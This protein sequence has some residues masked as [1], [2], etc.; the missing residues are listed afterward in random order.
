VNNPSEAVAPRPPRR[1]ARSKP[2]PSTAAS[3]TAAPAKTETAEA[4]D[5]PAAPDVPRQRIEPVL[6]E[7]QR[8][9]LQ[10]DV[11]S[12]LKQVDQMLG[13]ITARRLS[14]AEKGSVESIRSFVALSRKAL[15]RGDTQQASGLA[16]RALVLAQEMVRGR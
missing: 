2:G 9:Q 12:R 3:G 10:E 13:S 14:D 1:A 7:E 8:R 4:T 16:D 11:S 5:A 15:E 6:P